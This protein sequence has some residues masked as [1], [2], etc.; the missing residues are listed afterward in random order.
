MRGRL[1]TTDDHLVDEDIHEL[2]DELAMKLYATMGAKVYLLGRRDI[3]EL[4]GQYI[5]DLHPKDQETI[6]WL[7]WDLFQEAMEIEFG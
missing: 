3:V 5:E 2:V 6:P 7:M 4:V 1:F